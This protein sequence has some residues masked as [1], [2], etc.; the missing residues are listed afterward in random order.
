M[1]RQPVASS[2]LIITGL[3]CHSLAS[4]KDTRRSSRQRKPV[5][6]VHEYTDIPED[7]DDDDDDVVPTARSNDDVVMLDA[8]DPLA[9]SSQDIRKA[10]QQAKVRNY[11]SY[12]SL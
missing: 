2:K 11:F 12:L 9:I 4:S 5:S 6:Y 1:S 8:G 7:V 10:K 3:L